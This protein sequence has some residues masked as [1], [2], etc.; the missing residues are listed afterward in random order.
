MYHQEIKFR[1]A[2]FFPGLLAT[3]RYW[4]EIEEYHFSKESFYNSLFVGKGIVPDFGDSLKVAAISKKGGNLTLVVHPGFAIDGY[5]QGIFLYEPQALVL[6]YKK[7]KIPCT[8]YI[9]VQYSEVFE[10]YYQNK[11]NTDYQG[12]QKR[13]ESCKIEIVQSIKDPSSQIELARIYLS[14]D[15]N[16]EIPQ[17][18]ECENF[19]TPDKNTLDFRYVEWVLSAR[20]AM[21]PRL[22]ESIVSLLDATRNTASVAHDSVSLVGL[23]ELQTVAM[24][25]KMLVQCGDVKFDDLIHV[26][27]PLF[28]VCNQLIQEMLDFEREQ[29]KRFFSVKQSFDEVRQA[30][31]KMGDTIKYFDGTFDQLDV[32]LVNLR[33]VIEGLKTVI[34][35]RKVSLDSLALISYDFP[36]ILLVDDDRY[37]LMDFIDFS[38]RD[39]LNSHN[40]DF[41]NAKDISTVNQSA[42]YP[43][44]VMV[45]D[46][47][48]RYVGGSIQFEIHNI[49]KRRK[50]LIVRRTDI[51][52]GNYLVEIKLNQSVI[53]SIMVDASDTKDR[54]R[55]LSVVFEEE[56]VEDSR[57]KMEM[58]I[59]DKGRDNFGK[60]WIYQRI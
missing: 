37:S 29:E 11:E 18:L 27:Y 15:E 50:L 24:T 48:K 52:H 45:R 1:R 14:E 30:V 55:N 38:N 40:V 22:K 2:N 36:R 43:D 10:E 5:G 32:I 58:S 41:V 17:I 31:F 44:G 39:S 35:T 12:Y 8:I 28:D 42:T 16:G 59:G 3:P 7:F 46:V 9:V 26:M 13:L 51:F 53:R 19:F 49:I 20:K 56:E 33:N 47:L 4:N 34:I 54:W 23:R 57:G 60:I 25:A 6:D 21:A